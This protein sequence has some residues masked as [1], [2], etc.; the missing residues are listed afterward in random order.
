MIDLGLLPNSTVSVGYGINVWG[1]VV[2]GTDV[3]AFLY[4]HGQM[5]NLNDMIPSNS[6][7]QLE[8]AN[9]INDRGDIV[10]TGDIYEAMHGF[11]LTLDCKNRKNKD[12]DECKRGH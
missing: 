7:W 2:G 3:G 10:G 11:L 6:G 12:C 4:T 9:A 8:V 1:D 5:R